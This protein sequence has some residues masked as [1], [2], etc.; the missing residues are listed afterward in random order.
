MFS[1]QISRWGGPR[2]VVKGVWYRMRGRIGGLLGVFGVDNVSYFRVFW[3][4]SGRKRSR[5]PAVNF[6]KRF[7]LLIL[8][9]VVCKADRRLWLTVR[10]RFHHRPSV[11]WEFPAML[12]GC[13][14]N[15]T[16]V[17]RGQGPSRIIPG[18]AVDRALHQSRFENRCARRASSNKKTAFGRKQ[19]YHF[20]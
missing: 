7:T 6:G 20:F 3:L 11:V 4:T 13:G 5:I 8:L 18:P 16:G 10:L 19:F 1:G 9:L 14:E 12:G 15:R 17:H 2:R